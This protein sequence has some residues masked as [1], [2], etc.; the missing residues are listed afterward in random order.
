MGKEKVKGKKKKK[1]S[2]NPFVKMIKDKKA[3]LRRI[4]KELKQLNKM[5]STWKQ[6]LK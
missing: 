1:K 5:G 3:A 4:Q 2:K 6:M